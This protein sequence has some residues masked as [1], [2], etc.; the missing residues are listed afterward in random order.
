MQP[1]NLFD[2]AAQ[3]A[4]WLAVR[5]SVIAG[6]VANV[7]TPGYHGVDVKP[8]SAVLDDT[9][10]TMRATQPGH[11]GTNKPSAEMVA[12]RQDDDRTEL[13]PSGNSVQLED[14]LLKAADV[15]RSFELNTAIVRAFHQMMTMTT[16]G[17]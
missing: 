13:V 1:V 3:Q 12:L 15:R 9:Q 7:N 16:K 5:Q 6:N 14:E 11:F 4:R 2:L 8:F 10:V 17:T